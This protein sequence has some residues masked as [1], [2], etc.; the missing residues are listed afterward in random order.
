MKLRSEIVGAFIDAVYAI[1]A[2]I[3][4]LEI[5]SELSDGKFGIELV[6][7]V[8]FEYGVA[9]LLLFA[10]WLQHRIINGLTETTE[11]LGLLMNAIILMLV[12][13]IPRATKLVF[14][15]GD[16]VSAMDIGLALSGKAKW[17]TSE[18]VDIFYVVVVVVADLCMLLLLCVNRKN[19]STPELPTLSASKRIISAVVLVVMGASFLFPIEN[20]YFLLIIPVLLFFEYEILLLVRHFGRPRPS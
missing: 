2:T 12:C 11:R 17:T 16:D 19:A 15:Y 10:F 5:P 8:S 3:L 18:F 13:L 9:F 4:A 7:E 14:Q 6:T 1:A 20:R